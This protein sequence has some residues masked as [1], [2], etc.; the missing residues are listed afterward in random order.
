[1]G[2]RGEE[3]GRDYLPRRIET[4]LFLVC[5]PPPYYCTLRLSSYLQL[6]EVATDERSEP[7]VSFVAALTGLTHGV[8]VVRFAP[9][10]R[11][12]ASGVRCCP[13]PSHEALMRDWCCAAPSPVP[14][15]SRLRRRVL[16]GRGLFRTRATAG[17]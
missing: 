3:G 17:R 16:L 11:T 5:S 10:G 6:W 7:C 1:M 13:S 15:H 9:G 2:S 8:N 12:L 4:N 14:P